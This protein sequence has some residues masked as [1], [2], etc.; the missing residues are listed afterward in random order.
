MCTQATGGACLSTKGL[1]R[2]IVIWQ[3]LQFL[4]LAVKNIDHLQAIYTALEKSLSEGFVGETFFP[5]SQKVH[6]VG[7]VSSWV[8]PDFVSTWCRIELGVVSLWS[9]WKWKPYKLQI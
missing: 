1:C 8:P 9:S 2:I 6:L 7:F 5:K 3:E 4:R